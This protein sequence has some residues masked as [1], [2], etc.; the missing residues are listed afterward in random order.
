MKLSKYANK[1]GVCSAK[2]CKGVLLI[3]DVRTADKANPARHSGERRED[4]DHVHG[5]DRQRARIRSI[6]TVANNIP[7]STRPRWGKD[8]ADPS[9]FID[10][11]FV[12]AN[13]HAGRQQELRAR[14]VDADAGE[15]DGR[16]GDHS[17]YPQHRQGSDRMRCEGR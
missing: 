6:Q 8:Y 12:G 13:I 14:R 11:L 2:Q 9:T 3:Q 16:E 4:R 10:P 17:Q 15:A 7:I 5:A 1:G